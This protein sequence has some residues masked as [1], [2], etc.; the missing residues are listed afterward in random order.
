[1]TVTIKN[2][3]TTT[4]TATKSSRVLGALQAGESL[5]AKQIKSRF[6]VG[7]AR[8]LVSNLRMTGYS[9]YG[10]ARTNSKGETKTFYRLGQP[11]RAVV[12]AGYRALASA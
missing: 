11:S 1:M 7:N 6:G 2:S 10:N 9:V 5:T 12:A 3:K 4:K 8:A